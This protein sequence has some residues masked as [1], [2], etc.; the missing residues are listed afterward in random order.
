MQT[1]LDRARLLETGVAGEKVK[2]V[3]NIKF[4]RDRAPMDRRERRAWL[5]TLGLSYEDLVWVAGSTHRGEE[6][7]VIEIF[8]QIKGAFPRLRLVIAPRRL[9]RAEEVRR[10]AEDRGLTVVMRT[11][12]PIRASFDV[13]VLDTMGE[14]SRIYGI[15]SVSFVGGSLVPEGGHNLLEPAGFGCPVLFGPYTDDFKN[16]A[17]LLL[18][19]GGGMRVRDAEQL[20]QAVRALLSD[21]EERVRL[22]AKAMRFVTSNRGAL[23]RVMDEIAFFLSPRP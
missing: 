22:G 13:L 2:S 20:S 14:L 10:L 1:E 12:A 17:E 3:G 4:D 15:A 21:P 23:G 7:T 16:M 6:K 18:E 8:D 19:A 5:K 11:A 9:E